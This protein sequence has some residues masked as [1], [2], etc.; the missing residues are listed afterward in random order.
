MSLISR[1]RPAPPPARAP[2]SPAR[3]TRTRT[4]LEW[5]RDPRHILLA[6]V[7]LVVTYLAVV[8]AATMAVASLQ[9]SFLNTGPAEWTLRHYTETL[10]SA[11]FWTLVGNSFAYAAATAVLCTVI[12]FGLAYLVTRTNTPAKFFA[13]VAALIPLIIPGI[14]N[15]VAWALLFAPHTGALNVLLGTLHLPAFNIYSLSGMVLV[16][17]MHVT[18]VAFLMGTA[19]FTSMDSSLEEAALSS[20]APP[21]RV[22]R[23]ITARLIRP[24]IMSAAL[25]M[26]VQTISTFE[27]PQLIGV[28]GHTFVFV[29]RIYKA[30]QTF[31]TDYGT[32]GVTGIFILAVATVGLWLSRRLSG[33]GAAAQTIT[34]KGYRPT[35]TDIGRWRW[36]GLAVFVLFFVCAVALPLLMLVWSSLLPGYE[37]PSLSALHHLTLANYRDILAT[38]ALISSVRNSLVTAVLAGVIVTVLSSLVAYITV[39]TK[40]RGRG[41]LE[42]LA[43]VPLAVPSVVMGVGI[44]YWYLTAPIPFQMYGTLTILVIAFVTIGLPYG[45]RYIVPGMAQIKDELEEAA[46]AS[47]ATWLRTFRRIYVPLLVPSL[48]A[49]FLYTVI[50]AFREISAAIFLYTQDTQVVSVT[51]YQEWSNGSYPIVAALG[52]AIVV[53]LALIVALVRL[54]GSK[55]GLNRQ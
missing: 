9:S 48:L 38:P 15:T 23:T 10:G 53:F 39:K 28:P 29:S 31:P 6:V 44:L 17:S 2:L 50:V 19:A 4:V 18:P 37:P 47:G 42:G 27:V 21:R 3:S 25:L 7:A 55:T 35:V 20:G 13:Q 54:L 49:A 40:V 22:F 33:S 5:F 30:L 36:L 26:F 14:L 1:S 32:V 46:A 41:V 51:I 34:G 16:Q 52:V 43:T 24:A 12:G 45:L 11:D 8:P